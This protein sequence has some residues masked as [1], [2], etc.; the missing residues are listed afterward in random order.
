VA[1]P[2]R[3]SKTSSPPATG[4]TKTHELVA[5]QLRDRILSGELAPGDRLP[6]EDDLT[7]ETGV[8]RTT[9]REALRVL[10]SQGLITI[11]RGRGGGPVV[12]HPDLTP[13]ASALTIS[14]Q[15][16]QTTF[17]DL[18]AARRVIEP[19]IAA[20]LAR[21]HTKAEMKAL[22]RAVDL[23]DEA[24]EGGDVTRFLEAVVGVHETLIECSGNK[25][26]AT[27][28]RLLHELVQSFYQGSAPVIDRRSMR[29]AVRSY[30]KL[31]RLIEAGDADTAAAHWESQMTY[32]I[33]GRRDA[34]LIL[35]TT[36]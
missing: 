1:P 35:G 18:D 23:A 4:T 25:T 9:L 20:Q 21:R 11:R 13:A 8:A 10:E 22:T 31:L 27:I 15:L 17:A 26:L 14:L 12:T 2:S 29:G 7:A 34:H 28:S 33:S 32:T 30:R 19:H 3:K 16:Q 5:A 36:R 6:S 24:A